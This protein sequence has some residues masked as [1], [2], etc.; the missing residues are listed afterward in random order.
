MGPPAMAGRL[1]IQLLGKKQEGESKSSQYTPWRNGLLALPLR[2]ELLR[3][4]VY[5][6]PCCKYSSEPEPTA[7]GSA[8]VVTGIIYYCDDCSWSGVLVQ[9]LHTVQLPDAFL[10]KNQKQHLLELYSQSG[11][12]RFFDC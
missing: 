11:I 6:C 12:V 2:N 1:R 3:A 9:D 10:L 8:R 5:V 4:A 7:T